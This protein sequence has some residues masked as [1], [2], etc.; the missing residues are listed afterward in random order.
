[1]TINGKNIAALVRFYTGREV[2]PLNANT[3]LATDKPATASSCWG[4]GY[5]AENAFDG[6]SSTRWGA[7]PNAHHAWLEVELGKPVRIRRAIIENA[8]PELKR[9][10]KFAIET[11]HD[12][13]WIPC[14]QGENL[15]EKLE[16]TFDPVT[17]RRA[18]LNITEATD[19]PTLWEFQLFE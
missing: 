17:A 14:Y 13:Q 11:W 9:I 15:G 3:G 2:K 6:D 1:M 7:E 18:R 8:Y 16:V 12:G 5:E 10:R 19:T 4:A